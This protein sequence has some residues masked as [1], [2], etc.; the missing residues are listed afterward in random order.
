[1][2]SRA[3]QLKALQETPE[4]DVLI[5]GGGA[6]GAGV[7]LDSATRGFKTALVEMDDFSSGTSSRSTKLIH[8]G[9]RY[10]QKAIM[11][12]DREQVQNNLFLYPS[13]IYLSNNFV[14]L[15]TKWLKRLCTKEPIFSKLPLIYPRLYLLCFQFTGTHRSLLISIN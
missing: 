11:N 3:D 10:L 8:G 1:M 4:Y 12:F 7:A 2:L 5:I 14:P 15:S 9:V 13:E 6:T